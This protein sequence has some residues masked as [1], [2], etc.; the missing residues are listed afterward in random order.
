MLPTHCFCSVSS[1]RTFTPLNATP[2]SCRKP[3]RR[4]ALACYQH[5]T[6]PNRELIVVDDGDRFPAE[7]HAVAQAGGKLLQLPPGAILGTKLNCGSQAAS[8]VLCQKMDDDDWYAPKFLETMVGAFHHGRRVVCRPSLMFVSPFLFF[9]VA[10]WEIRRSVEN[11][12]PGATLMYAREDW[13]VRPFRNLP[14]DEDVWYY[15]DQTATGVQPIPIK[16]AEIF[17]AVRHSGSTQDRAHTWTH[18]GDGQT[19]ED[20]LQQRPL[21]RRPEDLLPPW[22]IEFY[23]GLQ[24]ELLASV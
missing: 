13:E 7:A 1:P 20:Y 2:R 24:Q 23:R 3:A 15:Q 16:D 17:L 19:L 8:G 10:R 11:N 21:H 9:E 18:Q 6:Y 14:Q 4:T 5:Q 12:A 22:A